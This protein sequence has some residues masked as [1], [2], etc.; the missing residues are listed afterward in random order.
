[1][2]NGIDP[3]LI[4]QFKKQLIDLSSVGDFISKIPVISEI[5]T[6]IEE[7]PIPVYLSES[8]TGVFIESED[9]SVDVNTDFETKTDGSEPDLNQKGASSVVSINLLARK[10]SLGVSLLAALIDLAFDKVTSNEYSV[11]YLHGPITV[12]RGKITQFVANQSP[13]N[14]LLSMKLEITRGEKQPQKQPENLQVERQSSAI[15]LESGG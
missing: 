3:I 2:L 4:F 5:P 10:D 8:I 12:F 6:L 9:K 11:S 13:N 7:P 14:Q 1:M 15:T